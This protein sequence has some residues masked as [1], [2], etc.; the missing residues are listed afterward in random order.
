MTDARYRAAAAGGDPAGEQRHLHEDNS[1][2]PLRDLSDFS[3]HQPDQF[4]S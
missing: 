2:L 1:F 3:P 4:S